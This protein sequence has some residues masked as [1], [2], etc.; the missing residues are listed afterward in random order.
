MLSIP[1]TFDF[2]VSI[3]IYQFKYGYTYTISSNNGT[4]FIPI[5]GVENLKSAIPRTVVK[6][7]RDRI[8]KKLLL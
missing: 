8:I 4:F 6:I 2:I 7:K 1:V 3:V 5:N